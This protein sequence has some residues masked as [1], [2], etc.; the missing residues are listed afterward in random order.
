VNIALYRLALVGSLF[1]I[2]ACGQSRPAYTPFTV[3]GE[4]CQTAR[5]HGRIEEVRKCFS[6][7]ANS[8][9]A[10]TR[11]EGLW[12]LKD[13]SGANDAFKAAE[14]QQ[15]KNAEMKVR[16]GRMYL[17]HWQPADAMKL[18]TEAL[19]LKEDH[20]G[21]LLGIALVSAE[22]FEQKAAE[23]AEKALKSDP[24][25]VEAQELLARVA[26]EDNNPKKA[27]EEADKAL[28]MSPEAIDALAIRATVDWMDD[29]TT[30]PWMDRILKINPV[31]GEAYATAAHFFVINRRYEEGIQFYRKALELTPDLQGARSE[32]GVN[33]MRLGRD[34]EARKF[35]EEAYNSG[36]KDPATVNTLRLMDSYK[37][38]ETTRTP[39][40]ILR[41]HKKESE[42]LRPYFQAELDRAIATYEKKYKI[43]LNAPVQLEVYPD[44]EDFAVR[45]MGMPGLGALGVTFGT[46]VAMDS[47]SG[48]KPGEWHWAST[49]WHELSHV[50]VLTATKHRVPRWFTEGLAVHEETAIAPDWGDRLTSDVINALLNSKLLPVA[51]LDR[52]FVHP[53]YPAQVIVS[54]YQAGKICDYIA[55]KWGYDRLLDMMHGFAAGKTT[56]EVVE[57]NLGMKPA[58]FDKQFLTWLNGQT[59]KTVVGFADWKKRIRNVSDALA[60]KDYDKTISEG[61]AIRDLYPDYV[62]RNSVYE[63]LADAYIGKGDKAAARKQ[64]EAYSAIGGRMP[65]V[66]K[67]LALMQ[68]EAGD[69]K[70][71]AATLNR[72]NYIYPLDE[73]LHKRLGDLYIALNDNKG[74]IRELEAVVNYKPIDPA[75]AHFAL[76]RAYNAAGNKE[77]AK[78]EV[79]LALEAAPGFKPAQRLLLE[80]DAKD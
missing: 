25:L 77:K 13:Y 53:S 49:L 57:A 76:A 2:N 22:H 36:Y 35:L 1:A 72:L 5:R 63:M 62:E 43:K 37:N 65:A 4:D 28:A 39:S 78:D 80:L 73:E 15:P 46:V 6:R 30:S 16:W 33:L 56:P 68:E 27:V 45:T 31:Y 34:G 21:A 44:H 12:G 69:K 40:T 50:F 42:V 48:R 59:Q 8:N 29:K 47:P 7:M 54:Y 26:L 23:M 19:G 14:K 61:N 64:L 41:L 60:A 66:I 70:A 17:D 18:F 32:L 24:K 11:A 51:E 3:P 67:K 75:G 71:A 52:G 55:E 74:A 38:F 79:L 9:D 20:A 58:D 10:W